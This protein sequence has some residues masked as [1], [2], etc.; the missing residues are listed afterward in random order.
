ME[1]ATMDVQLW[2]ALE[3]YHILTDSYQT[4]DQ[5]IPSAV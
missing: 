3:T 2:L 4:T 5:Q 1:T